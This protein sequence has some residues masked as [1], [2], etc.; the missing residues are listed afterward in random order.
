[1]ANHVKQLSTSQVEFFIKIRD[2]NIGSDSY[3]QQEDNTIL[4]VDRP[5]S[6]FTFDHVADGNTS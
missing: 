1:M 4:V 3:L 2:I 5:Y 6:L